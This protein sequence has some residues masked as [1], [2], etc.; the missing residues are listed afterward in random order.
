MSFANKWLRYLE[1]QNR[2]ITRIALQAERP[3]DMPHTEISITD[4]GE[5]VEQVYYSNEELIRYFRGIPDKI[6]IKP[7]DVEHVE[8]NTDGGL[9]FYISNQ[10]DKTGK[11]PM[12]IKHTKTQPESFSAQKE[13]ELRSEAR[14]RGYD[15]VEFI[16]T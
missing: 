10:K 12:K 2:I 5:K 8:I 13:A 14:K 7:L 16:P 3:E 9:T 15:V 6:E 11:Y 1:S 4:A